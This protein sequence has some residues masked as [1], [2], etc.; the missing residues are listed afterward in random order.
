MSGIKGRNDDGSNIE[1]PEVITPAM[2]KALAKV[3]RTQQK[4]WDAMREF[5]QLT[6]CDMVCSNDFIDYTE[7]SDDDVREVCENYSERF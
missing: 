5:E 3:A 6:G 7:P 1:T 4:F 2:R